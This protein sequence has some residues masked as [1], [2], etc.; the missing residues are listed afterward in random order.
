MDTTQARVTIAKLTSNIDCRDAMIEML[1]GKNRAD[2]ASI[3]EMRE[4]LLANPSPENWH[5][6]FASQPMVKPLEDMNVA[7][8]ISEISKGAHAWSR[9][10]RNAVSRAIR[11]AVYLH[12]EQTRPGAAGQPRTAY[13]LHPLRNTV[14]LFWIG[15]PDVT[16]VVA[17]LLH[18][19][20]ED[21]SRKIAV[22]LGYASGS[23]SEHQARGIALR[24]MRGEHGME[25]TDDVFAMTNPIYPKTDPP[26]SR[27]IKRD[28]YV[29][30]QHVC[31]ARPRARAG[32]WSDLC[33]NPGSLFRSEPGERQT[34]LAFKYLGAVPVWRKVLEA[35]G[36]DEALGAGVSAAQIAVLDVIEAQLICILADA[37]I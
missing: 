10:D 28:R 9:T 34:N 33:D 21:C 36:L 25:A 5:H 4:W 17:T 11:D 18:D 19:V 30:H 26:V 23:T 7:E 6:D 12:R 35:D 22:M 13:I 29:E 31:V 20:I 2:A 14:R 3:D 32:K 8:L 16:T 24:W 37:A 1:Q 27:E 15:S